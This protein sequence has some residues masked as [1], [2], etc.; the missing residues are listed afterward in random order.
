MPAAPAAQPASSPAHPG[1]MVT[2]KSADHD[3]S[4]YLVAPK[5]NPN[6]GCVVL[7][8]DIFGM[9]DFTKTEADQFSKLG[10][11]VLAPNL[12]SRIDGAA[13]GLDASQAAAAYK[14]TPDQQILA[15]IHAAIEYLN[16][17]GKSTAGQPLAIVG[18]DMGG[19]YAMIAAGLELRATCAVDFYGRL[20]YPE[21][22]PQ[23]PNSPIEQVFNL[24]VPFLAFYGTIDPQVP[25]QH[26]KLLESRLAANP[27]KAYYEVVKLP[28][29]GHG[30]LDPSRTGYNPEAAKQAM[31]QTQAFL[32][33]Y[34]QAP[35]KEDT[36]TGV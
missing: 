17:D 4:A 27:N 8:H 11:T 6:P 9:T 29:V 33:R 2:L 32:K 19:T 22:S 7:V 10:Y 21:T 34:L 28:G 14:A 18:I 35:K 15:D 24:D 30:F 3:I 23:R 12:Y 5:D 13:N 20:L 31:D 1:E 26:V 36:G 25:P 16:A